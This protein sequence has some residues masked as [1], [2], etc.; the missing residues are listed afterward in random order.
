MLTVV[1]S[2]EAQGTVNPSGSVQRGIGTVVAVSAIPSPGYVFDRWEG[3]VS[4]PDANPTSVT[5]DWPENPVPIERTVTAFFAPS[6]TRY[7]L[8]ISQDGGSVALE[9]SPQPPGGYPINT[10]VALTAYAQSGYTF[11][12]WKGNLSGIANP[13]SLLMDNEKSVTAVFNPTVQIGAQPADAGTVTLDPGQPAHGYATGTM[14]A[15]TAAPA[16]GYK[17]DGWGNDLSGS[18]SPQT[19]VVDSPKTITANF[20]KTSAFPWWWIAIGAGILLSL[21]MLV[22]L[23]YVARS[24]RPVGEE[25]FTEDEAA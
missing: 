4:A 13:S 1:S 9:P 17:F 5:I 18:E 6:S 10:T 25:Y 21:F 11:S 7:V 3:P 8:N 20:V 19:I 16:K 23:V 2:S 22:L 12:H 14:V 15:V 24:R